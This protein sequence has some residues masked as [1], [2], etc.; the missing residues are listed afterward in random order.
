MY[1]K[2]RNLLKAGSI[3]HLTCLELRH[4][5]RSF[6]HRPIDR[7]SNACARP[8]FAQP[9]QTRQTRST[10]P[11]KPGVKSSKGLLSFFVI[12]AVIQVIFRIF[13]F[14]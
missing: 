5:L 14:V 1:S 4:W 3:P 13:M 6:V 9:W 7:Q 12:G 10:W 11:P 2:N 8:E